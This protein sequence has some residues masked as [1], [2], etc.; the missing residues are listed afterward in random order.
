ME[1]RLPIECAFWSDWRERSAHFPS[2][3]R[4]YFGHETCEHLLPS[5]SAADSFAQRL[6]NR[7]VHVTFVTPFLSGQALDS[8]CATVDR[9]VETLGS[10][11][12]VS[13]DWGLLR[14]MTQTRHA[15]PIIGRLL[16]GQLTDPRIT[17]IIDGPDPLRPG[18]T[19]THQDGTV[20]EVRYRRPQS[21][22]VR[23][24][25]DCAMSKPEIQRYLLHMGI[26]RCEVNNIDQALHL[27]AVPGWTFSLHADQVLTAVMRV[28]PN[29]KAS[30]NA[31]AGH[32]RGCRDDDDIEA[33]SHPGFTVPLWRA[34]NGI[35]YRPR[36]L[37]ENLAT[38]PIDR[39]I[40]SRRP[41]ETE[42]DI[43]SKLESALDA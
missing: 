10:V 3:T 33:W 24:Y 25:R 2:G 35:Y 38:L 32:C 29:G 16:S 20:C 42:G 41:S 21:S 18:R 6:A 8:T 23:H 43:V 40:Y 9:L 22:L 31:S 15:T 13:S 34:Q 37:P 36:R 17:R 12:V 11:E 19:L 39:I 28:C 1:S 26:S 14:R 30:S 7:G 27:S 5:S 4:V